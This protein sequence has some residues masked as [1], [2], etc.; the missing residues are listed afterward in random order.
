MRI[1]ILSLAATALMLTACGNKAEKAAEANNELAE[2]AGDAQGIATSANIAAD[3][4]NSAVAS[5]NPTDIEIG[6]DAAKVAGKD[7]EKAADR[8]EDA[9]EKA[10]EAAH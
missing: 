4:T 5:G 8:V 9:A 3:F 6:T 10:A 2:A 7:A 1:A